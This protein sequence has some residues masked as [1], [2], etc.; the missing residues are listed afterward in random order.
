MSA[1]DENNV[2]TLRH[3]NQDQEIA[4]NVDECHEKYQ[5]TYNN[6]Y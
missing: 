3:Q 5:E 1:R 2:K 4:V 6:Y